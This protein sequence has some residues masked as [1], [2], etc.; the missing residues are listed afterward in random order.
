MFFWFFNLLFL[1]VVF[2]WL[3]V[4]LVYYEDFVFNN[5][6]YKK[7]IKIFCIGWSYEVFFI[8]R[9]RGKGFFSWCVGVYFCFFF[10]SRV[11][12]LWFLCC[13]VFWFFFFSVLI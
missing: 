5:L 6:I 10:I 13:C 4:G 2:F 3:D 8:I 7:D 12:V 11:G 1:E 9:E